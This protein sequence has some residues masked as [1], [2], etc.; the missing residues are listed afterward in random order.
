MWIDNIIQDILDRYSA[1]DISNIYIPDAWL[2]E[3]EAINGEG[4][5]QRMFP[6]KVVSKSGSTRLE[7]S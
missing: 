6:D 2:E 5:L 1:V 7:F 4:S 3:Y